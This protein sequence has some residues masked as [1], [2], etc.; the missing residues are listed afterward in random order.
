MPTVALFSASIVML[1]LSVAASFAA[2]YL[3]RECRSTSHSKRLQSLEIRSEQLESSISTLAAWVKKVQ[4]RANVA[5]W[6][7]RQADAAAQAPKPPEASDAASAKAAMRANLG[8]YGSGAGAAAQ[9]IHQ[10]A[11]EVQKQ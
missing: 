5:A 2:A 4:A 11:L 1:V 9:R 8:L 6:R 7:E 3:L 10:G